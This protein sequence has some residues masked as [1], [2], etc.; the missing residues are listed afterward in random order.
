MATKKAVKAATPQPASKAAQ[1]ASS[2]APAKVQTPPI[3]IDN[4]AAPDHGEDM[5]LEGRLAATEK[6][7]AEAVSDVGRLG[8]ELRELRGELAAIRS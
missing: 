8:G 4:I 5:S 6:A 1:P 3:H 7:Y 2:A